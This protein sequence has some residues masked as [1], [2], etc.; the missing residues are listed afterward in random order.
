LWCV[1]LLTQKNP[2]AGVTKGKKITEQSP[3]IVFLWVGPGLKQVI[4][5]FFGH[6][7]GFLFLY[8]LFDGDFGCR[9]F[10]FSCLLRGFDFAL[11]RGCLAA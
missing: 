6:C 4:L 5:A 2:L 3:F 8:N 9:P 7:Q 11:F 10:D 1:N